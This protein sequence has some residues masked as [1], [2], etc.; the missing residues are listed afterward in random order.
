[1]ALVPEISKFTLNYSTILCFVLRQALYS[2]KCKI[3][4]MLEVTWPKVVLGIGVKASCV[5]NLTLG[6]NE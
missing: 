1:M 4:D 5:L 2:V 3:V 6:K